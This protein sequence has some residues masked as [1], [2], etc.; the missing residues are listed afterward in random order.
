MSEQRPFKVGDDVFC[1][2]YGHGKVVDLNLN[3]E[4]PVEVK[5]PEE[6]DS[7]TTDG[8][9]WTGYERRLLYHAN[10]G[11]IEIDTTL[12]PELE[13]DDKLWV[14]GSGREVWYCRHFSHFDDHGKV[15]CFCNGQSSFTVKDD[16]RTASWSHYTLT[17]PNGEQD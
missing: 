7:Y 3:S 9:A 14:S 11:I 10:S 5:F 12:R 8:K 1:L 16:P 2:R 4:Y 15:A 13:V 6:S 17:D